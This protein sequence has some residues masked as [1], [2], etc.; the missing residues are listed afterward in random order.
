MTERNRAWEIYVNKV[1]PLSKNA[2]FEELMEIFNKVPNTAADRPKLDKAI[3]AH[4]S[5]KKAVADLNTGELGRNYTFLKNPNA[6]ISYV[7]L[8]YTQVSKREAVFK[9][10]VD[11]ALKRAGNDP[12]KLLQELDEAPKKGGKLPIENKIRSLPE[13]K[14]FLEYDKKG[15]GRKGSY[16]GFERSKSPSREMLRFRTFYEFSKKLPEGAK[17]SDY[18]VLPELLKKL[19]KD[20]I[21]TPKRLATEAGR[22]K[23]F[24][25]NQI[26]K[27]LGQPI[28]AKD[29]REFFPRPTD[30][31]VS[32]L[33]R[34]F[35]DGTYLFGKDTESIVRALHDNPE[36]QKL[37]AAKKFP[38]LHE[39]KPELEKFLKKSV[40][41]S[42]AAHGTRI[43]S[44]WTKGALYKNLGLDFKPSASEVKLGTRIYTALEGF[45]RYNPWSR[46]E[47]DHA[48]R[49]IKRNMPKE[50]GSLSSFKNQM[51]N[52]LPKGFLDKKNLNINE[53]FSIKQTA[54]N[55]SFPYAYFVDVIDADINQQNLSSFQGKLSTAVADTRNL[56]SRLRAGDPTVSY[57][58]I[59]DRIEKF[60]GERA[61]YAATIKRNFPGKNVNIADIVLGSE[62]EIL[63]RDF[64]IA[65]RVYSAKHLNKWKREGIDIARHAKTEGY[66][67]TGASKHTSFLFRDLVN[68]SKELW[69]KGSSAQQYE[70]AFK[71]KCVGYNASGGRIGFALG[72]GAINCVNTKIANQPVESTRALSTLDEGATGVLGKVRNTARGFLGMLGR[73]GVKAAP[74]AA[75]AAAGAA[76]EPLVKQ[77]RSDDPTTYLSDE[78]QQKGMLLSMIE[79]ETPKVDEEI[80]KWQMP[81]HGAATAAGAIPGAKTLYQERRGVGPKG[82]LPK[83]VG[84]TRAAL[85]LSGV[86]GKALG[87]SF[88]PLVVGATLPFDIAAQRKGGS[89]WADI[90]TSPGNWM[91]PAFMGSGYN[92]ASKGIV[93]PT[94][95]KLLRFGI[96]RSALAAM[97][98]VGWAGLAGSLGL[99]GYDM[100]KN[101]GSKKKRFYDD[102]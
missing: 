6:P 77:F 59:T 91:G 5:Y 50:A 30:T 100:W 68:V 70:V 89:D 81:A 76:I 74:Y 41:D 47:Y 75:I 55:K 8:A 11:A 25:F 10:Y 23:F 27:F 94:L 66:A 58:D 20:R 80:L 33:R 54:K 84:K 26:V 93:N 72:T 67:M 57:A 21:P 39:F 88:S 43:Y 17:F 28:A 9:K 71:L 38:K 34:F 87:A 64:D 86:L 37:L 15:F 51:S 99:A 56:I 13:Y 61:T 16:G 83:G 97:G 96:S 32:E 36:L 22:Y 78:N 18:I 49:E 2:T 69:K 98:P 31:Q 1:L 46:G 42:Q 3:R 60:Q 7:K 62:K 12:I 73:G 40:T 102:D 82:P 95:L 52:Y 90:A 44:D 79:A 24:D 48:M 92:I 53:I 35:K 63:K 4:P 14:E 29:G 85:G 19:G 45:H 101:R 65:D